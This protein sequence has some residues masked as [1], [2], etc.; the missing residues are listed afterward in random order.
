MHAVPPGSNLSNRFKGKEAER[1]ADDGVGG[2]E[3]RGR[4]RERE[5]AKLVGEGL[6]VHAS[7]SLGVISIA[8]SVIVPF[9]EEEENI[10]RLPLWF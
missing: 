8:R 5:R 4:G 1:V 3:R 10:V 6:F 9:E 7:N 2:K